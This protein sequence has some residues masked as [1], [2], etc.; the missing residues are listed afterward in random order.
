MIVAFLRLASFVAIIW[1]LQQL[2]FGTDL[3]AAYPYLW[4]DSVQ[5]AFNYTL[6]F[7][8]GR[9]LCAP[10]FGALWNR[11]T[12][13]KTLTLSEGLLVYTVS[14][15][16]GV[17]MICWVILRLPLEV[18]LS[19]LP[20]IFVAT[21]FDAIWQSIS[22][23][24]GARQFLEDLEDGKIDQTDQEPRQLVVERVWP[25]SIA[26]SVSVWLC[27]MILVLSALLV[28]QSFRLDLLLQLGQFSSPLI[29][30]I[31]VTG[32]MMMHFGF[33]IMRLLGWPIREHRSDTIAAYAL[34]MG[35]VTYG[36]MIFS[37][38]ISV[39]TGHKEPMDAV[40]SFLRC[41]AL[42]PT[43]VFGGIVY[44]YVASTPRFTLTEGIAREFA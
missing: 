17:G 4:I 2:G 26:A 37:L 30:L 1:G 40:W 14:S 25:A 9:S 22:G 11:V 3:M 29:L 27:L 10:F 16:L 21:A 34:S 13:I 43:F 15:C 12:P 19:A 7:W 32:P 5:T 39:F 36:F 8:L 33:F 42:A 20:L 23:Y 28:A 38:A 41:F 31:A 44:A 18:I 6:V 24:R 35:T